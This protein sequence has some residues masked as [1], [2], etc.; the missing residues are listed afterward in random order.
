MDLLKTPLKT[1]EN[2]LIVQKKVE[3]F[4]KMLVAIFHRKL[5]NQLLVYWDT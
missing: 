4:S 1:F 5:T 2:C 3:L